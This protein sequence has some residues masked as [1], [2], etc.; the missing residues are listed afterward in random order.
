MEKSHSSSNYLFNSKKVNYYNV[1]YYDFRNIPRVKNLTYKQNEIDHKCDV[2]SLT[3]IFGKNN[4]SKNYKNSQNFQKTENSKY[5]NEK[6]LLRNSNEKN[7]LRNSKNNFNE[8]NILRNSNEKNFQRRLTFGN[9]SNGKNF[10]RRLSFG[11]NLNFQKEKN[12]EKTEKDDFL[13]N[14]RGSNFFDMYSSK[15]NNFKNLEN[16]KNNFGIKI[17]NI[18]RFIKVPEY[19]KKI[20]ESDL[21]KNSNLEKNEFFQNSQNYNNFQ[22][23]D[24]LKSY[25][26]ISKKNNFLNKENQKL[27]QEIENLRKSIKKN[28][29]DEIQNEEKQINFL[30]QKIENLENSLNFYEKKTETNFLEKKSNENLEID[31]LKIQIKNLEKKIQNLNPEKKNSNFCS[32]E[33]L[34]NFKN[35]NFSKNNCINSNEKTINKYISFGNN[36]ENC[37]N[38]YTSKS[39]FFP[40]DQKNEYSEYY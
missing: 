23:E 28:F 11:N 15:K 10:Q 27:I 5:N 9:N 7:L 14:S 25:K 24:I 36:K 30:G 12:F 8:K 32:I 18:D 2:I 40:N 37:E 13:L 1:G 31:D 4:F 20:I 34:D 17:Q 22:N 16:E 6:N 35:K 26:E 39:N 19:E 33:N 3:D 29:Y 21:I 38:Y